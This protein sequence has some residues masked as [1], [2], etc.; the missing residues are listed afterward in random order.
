MKEMKV[1]NKH[2]GN[3]NCGE[4]SRVSGETLGTCNDQ[5]GGGGGS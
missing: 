3:E 1:P 2:G 4:D 5:V